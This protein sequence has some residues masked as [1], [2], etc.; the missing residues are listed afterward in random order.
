MGNTGSSGAGAG[1][2]FAHHQQ[3]RRQLPP[4]E[5]PFEDIVSYLP[6]PLVALRTLKCELASGLAPGQAEET[7]A[8]DPDWLINGRWGVIQFFDPGR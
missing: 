8:E 5:T 1:G 3:G 4:F 6:A 2:I 7:T